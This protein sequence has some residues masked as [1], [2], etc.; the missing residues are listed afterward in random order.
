ME[1]GPDDQVERDA[2]DAPFQQLAGILRARLKRGDWKTNRAIPGENALADEYG[3]SRPTVRRAIAAL[4][5]EGL[6][7]ALSGRGTYVAEQ[8]PEAPAP[9]A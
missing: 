6:L 7:Y 1:Y 9:D 5:D 3:L 4:A 8:K 2:P